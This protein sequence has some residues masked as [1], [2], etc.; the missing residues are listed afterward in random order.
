MGRLRIA[1]AR[2]IAMVDGT[3]SGYVD[4]D[5]PKLTQ[6]RTII[7]ALV[8]AVAPALPGLFLLPRGYRVGTDFR[9]AKL[10]AAIAARTY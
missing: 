10:P 1:H 9:A 2:P 4:V 5:G 7:H 8:G 3:R 6:L